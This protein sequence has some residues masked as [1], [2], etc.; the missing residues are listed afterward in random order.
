MLKG[1][2]VLKR[3]GDAERGGGAGAGVLLRRKGRV[4]RQVCM[5]DVNSEQGGEF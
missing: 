2:V 4:L 1:E 5:G 3:E